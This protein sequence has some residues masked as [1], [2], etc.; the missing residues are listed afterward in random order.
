LG[1]KAQGAEVGPRKEGQMIRK[2]TLRQ[3]V[4][5]WGW[6]IG[7]FLVCLFPFWIWLAIFHFVGPVGFWQKFVIVGGGLVLLGGLQIVMLL[8]WLWFLSEVVL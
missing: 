2:P 4:S 8:F 3:R 1:R 7:S 5:Q 6:G